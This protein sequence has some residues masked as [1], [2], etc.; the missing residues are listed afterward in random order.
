MNVLFIDWRFK[1]LSANSRVNRKNQKKNAKSKP[2]KPIWK[3]IIKFIMLCFLLAVIGIGAVIAYFIVTTP[4]LDSDKLQIPYATQYLDQN[5]EEFADKGEENRKEIEYEE[6]PEELIDAVVATEDSR[7]FEH[8]GIDIRRIGGA[9]KANITR[10]FGSEGASTITQQVVEQMYLTP[11]KSIKRKVQE[12]WLA[13]KLERKY[14]KEEIL[15]MYLNK[16]Y[17]GSNAYGVGKGAETYFGKDDLSD[18]NLVESA[19]LAGLPQRPSGYNPFEHP[20]NMQKRMDTV[21]TLMERHGKIT[22]DEADEARDTDV[23]SVLSDEKTDSNPYDA[24]IG[25][26][27]K[28]LEEKLDDP[29][30]NATGL[31]VHTTL[32]TDAQDNVEELLSDSENNP[33]QFPDDELQA[34]MIVLDTKSGAVRAIGGG[35]DR[36]TGDLNYAFGFPRQPGSVF[37]PLMS[38]APA[39]ENEQYSTYHQLDDDQPYDIGGGNEV[40]NWNRQY[41]GWMTMRNALNQSLNV[42]TLKLAEDVGID[43]SQEFVEGLGID[44]GDESAVLADAIGDGT[45]TTPMDVAGAYAAFGNEGMYTEPYTVTEVEFPDGETMDLEPE[46]EAAMSDYTAYMMTDML[47]SVITEGTGKEANIP[48]LD[49]AGKTGTTNPPGSE[50]TN[51]SWFAG[52][53]SDYTV[54]VWTGYEDNKESMDNTKIP[55]QLFKQTMQR[56][57]ENKQPEAFQKPDSVVELEVENG[58][59]P[60]ALP[61]DNTPSDKLITELFVK[62]NEPTDQSDEYEDL[63]AVSGLKAEFKDDDESIDIKWDY[64]KEDD[65]VYEVAYKEDDGDSQDLTTTEDKE[66]TLTGVDKGKKYTIEVVAKNEETDTSSDPASTTVDLSDETV[67]PVSDLEA[68]YDESDEK[69]TA[70]W[71]HEDSDATFEV[72]VNGKTETTSSTSIDIGDVS[73]GNTY[74]IEVIAIIDDNESD[75]SSTEVTIDDE[76]NDEE[77]EN[78]ENDDNNNDEKDDE[79]N[80][81]EEEEDAEENNDE[82][83]EN[84]NENENNE[85]NNENENNNND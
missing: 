64:D 40:R 34:G 61:S 35:R 70:N 16:I 14:S 11:N 41:K 18:L 76:D 28:E 45:D 33:I 79:N 31:K 17:Y 69:I 55:H 6:L 42:P 75:A 51:N 8:K 27:D 12:Q 4:K 65:I 62:G 85:N 71:S 72:D 30:L 15:E 10:G 60:A 13:L 44:F 49:V 21:L 19:M 52:Y 23:T 29:N 26:V 81:N 78:N 2:K 53:T 46:S 39:I 1:L 68:S 7:F 32:D 37:K 84:N 54:S 73:S 22:A 56:L 5:G 67:E 63:E 50:G 48:G 82:N 80:S 3:K 66:A 47:K 25:K 59:R 24:F 58:S 36:E 74:T 20:E 83:D 38:Y 77:N 43:Q 9:I 57:A